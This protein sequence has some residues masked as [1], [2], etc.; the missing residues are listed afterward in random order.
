[1]NIAV[2]ADHT[3]SDFLD[4]PDLSDAAVAAL[5]DTIDR[6]G[7]G[8]VSGYM[9]PDDINQLRLFAEDAVRAAGNEY[10]GF[11]GY[12]KL[13]GT[14]LER[15]AKSPVFR[16][17]CTRL[18]ERATGTPAPDQS[19]YQILRCL[20]GRSGQR[21]SLNFHYDS[22]VVTVLVPI[23]IPQGKTSGQLV[24]IPNVRPVRKWYALNMLDK[25][26]VDNG[27]SHRIL[28]WMHR[29][30]LPRIVRVKMKPGDLCVFWGYRSIHSNEPC[31]P[32]KIRA[33]ALF[34]YADPHRDSRLKKFLGRKSTAGDA[35]Y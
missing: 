25:A 19:Y 33:T 31:D 27:L 28:K 12:D 3:P 13:L 18:Y 16:S 26:R 7:Y 2:H 30:N 24:M 17:L 6:D 1:M 22:Y 29:A 5:A 21:H 34:H 32:D 20:A 35:N 4:F 8:I 11:G 23:S 10:V 15:M 14:A 9:E